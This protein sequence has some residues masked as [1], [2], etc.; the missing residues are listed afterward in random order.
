MTPKKITPAAKI[1]P[2]P[3]VA[4]SHNDEVTAAVETVSVIMPQKPAT[5]VPK[6][7]NTIIITGWMFRETP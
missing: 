6:A 5:E 4:Q 3:I 2:E 1:N 7:N